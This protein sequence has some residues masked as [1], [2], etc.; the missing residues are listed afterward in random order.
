M[1][2]VLILLI[3]AAMVL[4]LCACGKEEQKPSDDKENAVVEETA[5]AAENLEAAE[6]VKSEDVV[7]EAVTDETPAE[8]TATSLPEIKGTSSQMDYE[9][10]GL[11]ITKAYDEGSAVRL[12]FKVTNASNSLRYP[13]YIVGMDNI[14]CSQNGETLMGT[15]LLDEQFE[16][17]IAGCDILPGTTVVY[18]EK[19]E[20][21]N[22]TDVISVKIKDDSNEYNFDV[23]PATFA[24]VIP[25]SFDLTPVT[26][27]D[28]FQPESD[29]IEI[30]GGINIKVL[31]CELIK[32]NPW[33]GSEEL[34][35]VRVNY[36][37]TN[38]SDMDTNLGGYFDILQDGVE[39]QLGM[40]TS[41]YAADTD[42]SIT[43]P[44]AKGETIQYSL[45]Y[46]LYNTESP[47]M[48]V[49]DDFSARHG[50]TFDVK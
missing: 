1:K 22:D 3:S 9:L 37:A 50:I 29:E 31:G 12:W 6:D 2:K 20:M 40:P 11:D 17:T 46:V 33:T 47:V 27:S 42:T 21:L 23:D 35:C 49:Y 14:V 10:V 41:E 25:E 8:E 44:I 45:T 13:S 16:D 39:L 38:N 26:S 15:S 4:G 43:A 32:G 34:D 30:M 5:E 28:W 19:Y 24:T 48:V 18:T 7:D 36:E